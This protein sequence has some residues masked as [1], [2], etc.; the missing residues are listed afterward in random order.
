MGKKNQATS[1]S[2][3][4]I[5]KPSLPTI[6]VANIQNLRTAATG[7]YQ[8]YLDN[9]AI[10]GATQNN[11]VATAS[12]AY[13]LVVTNAQGCASSPSAAVTIAI[14]GIFETPIISIYPNPT[15]DKITITTESKGDIE[16]IDAIGIS[17]KR[18]SSVNSG[19][20][21]DISSLTRG[22]YILRFTDSK[23]RISTFS[24]IKD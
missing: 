13:T 14:T 17:V 10:T 21:L 2:L 3:L 12:G 4:D 5:Q 15:R 18:F 16:I 23:T 8:W 24:L 11:Y 7:Y 22:K 1:S 19:D 9:N 6:S 20:I